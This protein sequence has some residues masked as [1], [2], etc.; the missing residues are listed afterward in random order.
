MTFEEWYGDDAVTM[1]ECLDWVKKHPDLVNLSE[2]IMVGKKL[3]Q[4][5]CEEIW[6]N[7]ESCCKSAYNAGRENGC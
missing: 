5:D 6:E 2:L 1:K 4:E 3:T 7:I